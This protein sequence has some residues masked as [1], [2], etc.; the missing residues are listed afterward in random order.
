[1]VQNGKVIDL[2]EVLKKKRM[3]GELVNGIPLKLSESE[4]PEFKYL[5]KQFLQKDYEMEVDYSEYEDVLFLFDPEGNPMCRVGFSDSRVFVLKPENHIGAG[6]EI[7]RLAH[8]Y[9]LVSTFCSSWV[10]VHKEFNQEI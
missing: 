1:M 5:L 4:A 8:S 2:T 10:R 7:S 6:E 3:I 9:M